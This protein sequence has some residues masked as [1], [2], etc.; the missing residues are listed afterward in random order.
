MYAVQITTE[1]KLLIRVGEAFNS[2]TFEP[3]DQWFHLVTQSHKITEPVR[4]LVQLQLKAERTPGQLRLL[5]VR[6]WSRQMVIAPCRA[7]VPMVSH[8]HG[9]FFLPYLWFDLFFLQL[10]PCPFAV[11]R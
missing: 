7:P 1:D 11:H 3:P 6:V 9:A 5:R 2:P 10:A 8:T 4:S